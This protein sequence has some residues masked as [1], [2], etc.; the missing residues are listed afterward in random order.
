MFPAHLHSPC[1]IHYPGLR[2]TAMFH[3]NFSTAKNRRLT[4]LNAGK[5]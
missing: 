1:Q 5:G 2:L 4:S 3:P